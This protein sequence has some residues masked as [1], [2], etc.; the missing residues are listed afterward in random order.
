MKKI[1]CFGLC[2]MII[3]CSFV[4]CFA[5]GGT[6][7]ILPVGDSG[8]TTGFYVP[9][10][11]SAGWYFSSNVSPVYLAAY[12]DQSGSKNIVLFSDESGSIVYRYSDSS[13]SHTTYNLNSQ[14]NGFY[15]TFSTSAFL[16]DSI[17]LGTFDSPQELIDYVNDSVFSTAFSITYLVD[18]SVLWLSSMASAALEHPLLLFLILAGFTGIAIGLFNRFRR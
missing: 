9:V 16:S 11:N 1:V 4:L 2:F 14:Y 3:L 6:P 12:L 17:I 18:G 5:D 8:S 10:S 7:V 13:G 15:Y